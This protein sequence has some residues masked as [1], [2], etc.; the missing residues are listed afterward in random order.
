MRS[1]VARVVFEA[2]MTALVRARHGYN[3]ELTFKEKKMKGG[4]KFSAEQTRDPFIVSM[5]A[6][7]EK[8]K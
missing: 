8:E 3:T 2:R 5:R 1:P 7:L 4:M 6:F